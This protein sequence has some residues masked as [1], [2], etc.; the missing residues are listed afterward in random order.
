MGKFK[1]NEFIKKDKELQLQQLELALVSLSVKAREGWTKFQEILNISE[2]ILDYWD[3]EETQKELMN[4][5]NFI[6]VKSWGIQELKD[7]DLKTKLYELILEENEDFLSC[8]W[9]AP[10][11]VNFAL[12]DKTLDELTCLYPEDVLAQFV[13]LD[14]ALLFIREEERRIKYELIQFQIDSINGTNLLTK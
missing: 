10:Y 9:D 3:R 7:G 5:C 14:R 1:T 13:N 6:D 11:S 8:H 4:L 2:Q 12:K